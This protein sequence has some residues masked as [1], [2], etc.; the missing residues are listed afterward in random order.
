MRPDEKPSRIGGLL[1]I[2]L[3]CLLSL[4]SVS[5]QIHVWAFHG[6]QVS[7]NTCSDIHTVCSTLPDTSGGQESQPDIPE[8]K[9]EFCPVVLFAQ[10]VTLVDDFAIRLPERLSVVAAIKAEPHMVWTSSLK[11]EVQARAPPVS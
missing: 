7:N 9:D 2:L 6:K 5:P 3:V 8:D 1:C 11:G 4:A 10:G